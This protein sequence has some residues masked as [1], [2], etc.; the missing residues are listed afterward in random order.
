MSRDGLLGGCPGFSCVCR[1]VRM[2]YGFDS[3]KNALRHASGGIIFLSDQ[4]D[5]WVENKVE[6]MVAALSSVDCVVSDCYVTD[7]S[8]CVMEESFVVQLLRKNP[9][10]PLALKRGRPGFFL[11]YGSAYSAFFSSRRAAAAAFTFSAICSA[12]S[13]RRAIFFSMSPT[14]LAAAFDFPEKKERF[15]S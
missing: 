2:K 10:L 12:S 5:R 15:V 14:R 4:D 6:R 13:C 1:M 8:L 9:G 7:G 11:Y 3:G